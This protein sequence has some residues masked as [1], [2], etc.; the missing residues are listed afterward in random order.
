MIQWHHIMYK[1]RTKIIKT[2]IS[3]EPLVLA[4]VDRVASFVFFNQSLFWSWLT[5]SAIHFFHLPHNFESYLLQFA[6]PPSASFSRN[7]S[8][9]KGKRIRKQINWRTASGKSFILVF[10]DILVLIINI[11]TMMIT[12]QRKRGWQ[13]KRGGENIQ[14]A[15]GAHSKAKKLEAGQ[16]NQCCKTWSV[17]Q[18]SCLYPCPTPCP[19]P[20]MPVLQCSYLVLYQC[21]RINQSIPI[22]LFQ[23]LSQTIKPG[24]KR[25]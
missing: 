13:T 4:L 7:L 14:L 10:N 19:C 9:L 18:C 23:L 22:S 15:A 16:S 6:G 8:S 12:R 5:K 2:K 11:I 1:F 20:T 3:N 25:N 21:Q 24:S 17:L